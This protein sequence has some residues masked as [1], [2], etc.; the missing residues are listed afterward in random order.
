MWMPVCGPLPERRLKAPAQMI[1]LF[2]QSIIPTVP[3]AWLILA[4][5]PVYKVYDVP[6]RMFGWSTVTDQQLAG[7]LMKLGAGTYLWILIVIVFF[8]WVSDE[9]VFSHNPTIVR[10]P[11]VRAVG[12]GATDVAPV[13]DLLGAGSPSPAAEAERQLVPSPAG[14]ADDAGQELTWAEV[15]AELARLPSH[16]PPA[17][18]PD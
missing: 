15:E 6:D 4:D 3:S 12:D 1:Y 7:L 2:C 10:T 9:D 11:V 5:K 18:Q 17:G 8:R 14:T 16:Q 13:V